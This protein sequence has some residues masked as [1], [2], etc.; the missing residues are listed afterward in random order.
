MCCDRL[1][2]WTAELTTVVELAGHHEQDGRMQTA[3]HG[4]GTA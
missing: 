3:G 4:C 2:D 1:P